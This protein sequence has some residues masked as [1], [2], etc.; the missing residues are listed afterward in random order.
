MGG[1]GSTAR[2]EGVGAEKM[3]EKPGAS[4]SGGR[5]VSGS[6]KADHGDSGMR[7]E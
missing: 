5:E 2:E 3:E 1:E 7:T 6:P 4:G